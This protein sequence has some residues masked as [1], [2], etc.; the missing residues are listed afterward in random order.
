LAH[1]HST[2]S[3]QIPFLVR[4]ENYLVKVLLGV[5]RS[6]AQM[7]RDTSHFAHTILAKHFQFSSRSDPF[8]L[9]LTASSDKIV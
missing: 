2:A 6:P 3:V 9:A 7:K 1:I 5:Y 8:F 4:D